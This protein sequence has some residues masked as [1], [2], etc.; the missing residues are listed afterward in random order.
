MLKKLDWTSVFT[1]SLFLLLPYFMTYVMDH[2]ILSDAHA[3]NH[4]YLILSGTG[5]FFF[6][7]GVLNIMP[8][9]SNLYYRYSWPQKI[10]SVL[11]YMS[12]F[13]I[14]FTSLVLLMFASL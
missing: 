2:L 6:W 4:L 9:S 10:L 7:L 13:F 12:E 11:A 5:F 8:K 14:I 1:G 3:P